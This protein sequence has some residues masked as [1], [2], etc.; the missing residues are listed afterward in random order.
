MNYPKANPAVIHQFSESKANNIATA[1][2]AYATAC[3]VNWCEV[4]GDTLYMYTS[5]NLELVGIKE[6]LVFRAP[7]VVASDGHFDHMEEI[8]EEAIKAIG[9]AGFW[10][11]CYNVARNTLT[12]LSDALTKESK[13]SKPAGVLH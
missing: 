9:I 12:D 4:D 8:A 3:T 10:N 11:S 5:Y 7:L 13:R 1:F 6:F 2:M